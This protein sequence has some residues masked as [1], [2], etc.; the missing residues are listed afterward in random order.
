MRLVHDSKGPPTPNFEDFVLGVVDEEDAD[1]V[2][3]ILKDIEWETLTA[4][5]ALARGEGAEDDDDD[6][7][8]EEDLGS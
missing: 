3:E 8:E 7:E 4:P 6:E 2:A 1:T 5:S